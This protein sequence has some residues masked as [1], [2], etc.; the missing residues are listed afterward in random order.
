MG[1]PTLLN[2]P[3][4]KTC[5]LGHKPRLGTASQGWAQAKALKLAARAS[6]KQFK[7]CVLK[8]LNE[9]PP[10]YLINLFKSMKER[11]KSCIEANGGKTKY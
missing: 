5:G 4:L 7:A 8:T 9:V 6:R 10:S 1:P 3:Q 11:V 2:Y